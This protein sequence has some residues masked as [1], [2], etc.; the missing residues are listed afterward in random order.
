MRKPL[1]IPGRRL[2]LT[3]NMILDAQSQTKSAAQASRWLNVS[4]N[5]YKKWAKYYN[6]FDQHKN[7]I[8]VGI[9]K[10]PLRIEINNLMSL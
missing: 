2:V 6:V 4:Y 7:Q 10:G 3:K 9:K 5:T 1:H 8:G